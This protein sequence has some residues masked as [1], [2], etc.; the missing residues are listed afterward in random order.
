[1]NH[2][3]SFPNVA[4]AVH[5]LVTA[6]VLTLLFSAG[7]QAQSSLVWTGVTDAN[8]DTTT[9]NWVTVPGG[10]A[11]AFANGDTVLFD[12]TSTTG[13]VSIPSAVSPGGITVNKAGELAF[14][15]GP[16]ITG[17]TTLLKQNSGTLGITGIP[18]FTG[19]ASVEGGVVAINGNLSASSWVFNTPMQL[20]GGTVAFSNSLNATSVLRIDKPVTIPDGAHGVMN[21]TRTFQTRTTFLGA[22]TLTLNLVTH[23]VPRA[24]F[25]SGNF[26]GFSGELRLIGSATARANT[27]FASASWINTSMVLDT[28]GLI[29]DATANTTRTLDI[30]AL[31]SVDNAGISSVQV[32]GATGNTVFSIG[33]R[34]L[35]TTFHGTIIGPLAALT[36]VGSGMLTLTGVNTYTG[37]TTVA[38]GGLHVTGQLANTAQV[39]VAGGAALGGSGTITSAGVTYADDATLLVDAS[40]SGTLHGLEVGGPVTLGSTLKVTPVVAD[41][42][43]IISGVY[44]L[45]H[46]TG[47]IT[48]SPAITLEYSGSGVS[49]A[50][51]QTADAIT[52]TIT[53]G[54]PPAPVIT[55]LLTA[56]GTEGATFTYTITADNNPTSFNATALPDGLSVNTSSGVISG[57]LGYGTTGTSNITIS[58]GNLGGTDSET[59]AL[60]IEPPPAPVNVPT[61][62]GP[63]AITST[64]GAPFNYQIGASD[65][66]ILEYGAAPLPAA[67]SIDSASGL[68]SG[69]IL[70]SGTTAVVLSA[71]NAAGTGTA[72]LAISAYELPVITSATMAQAADGALFSYT[73][74]AS[75]EPTS[76]TASGLP[77]WLSYNNATHVLS[78]TPTTAGTAN[79]TMTA[80]NPVGSDTKT[81]EITVTTLSPVITSSLRVT[82]TVGVP[83]SYQIVSD[84]SPVSY[85]AVPLPDGLSCDAAT[86]II[87]GVPAAAGASDVLISATNVYGSDEAVLEIIA[88][89]PVPADMLVWTGAVSGT[90]NTTDQNWLRA[91]APATYQDGAKVLFND[92]NETLAIGGTG[93]IGLPETVNPESVTF[94]ISTGTLNMLPV[95]HFG[96]WGGATMLK[97][98]QGTV[99]FSSFN[100]GWNGTTTI[101]EGHLVLDYPKSDQALGQHTMAIGPVVFAGGTLTFTYPD[102]Q[103]QIFPDFTV[104]DGNNAVFNLPRRFDFKGAI[105]GSG[106]L[107]LR[108]RGLSNASARSNFVN[109]FSG[110]SGD[111]IFTGS[112]GARPTVGSAPNMFNWNGWADVHLAIQDQVEIQPQVA[113]AGN[114]LVIGALSGTSAQAALGSG[115]SNRLIT[116]R[117]GRK[118]LSTTFAGAILG[119]NGFVNGAGKT[120]LIKEG[121]GL[122]TLSGSLSYTGTT[123]VESGGLR[124]TGKHTGTEPIIVSGSAG[125]GGS[126]EITPAITYADG[127]TL[128]LDTDEAGELS[129]P[130]V[131]GGTVTFGSTLKVSPVVAEGG[132]VTNGV[133]TIF[134]SEAAFAGT[135]SLVWSHPE[136]PAVAAAFDIVNGSQIQ[137]TI[138]GGAIARPR[139]TSALIADALAG[140]PFSYTLTATIDPTTP[141]ILSVDGLPA[142][143]SFNPA[144]GIISGSV[145]VADTYPVALSASNSSGT[146]T[147]TLALIVYATP[148]PAPLITSGTRV[149]MVVEQSGAYTITAN[150]NPTG[151]DATDLPDGLS[152][153]TKTGVIS[154]KPT[155]VGTGTVTLSASNI[156]GTGTMPLELVVSLPPPRFSEIRV[157]SNRSPWVAVQ[158]EPVKWQIVAT[159][160]PLSYT[161]SV[162][163]AGFDTSFSMDTV[164]GILDAQFDMIG[165][166]TLLVTYANAAGAVTLVAPFAVNPPSPVVIDA[167]EQ[168]TGAVGEPFSYT[169][170]ATNMVPGGNSTAVGNTPSYGATGLPPGLFI[171]TVTGV[172]SG[173]P[174]Y[175]GVQQGAL[176]AINVT[177]VGNKPVSFAISGASAVVSLA[178]ESGTP[179]NVDGPGADA[180]FTSPGAGI[181]DKDG[182]LYIADT[183]NNSIRK[184]ALDGTV[185]TFATG[186]NAPAS[187]VVDAAG[188]TLY[189]ANTG[190][191]TIE[192]I[193]IATATVTALA[194]TGAPALNAPHGL[195]IDSDG[196]LYVADTG[197][198]SIR[199]INTTTGD[200]TVIAGSGATGSDDGAGVAA[201]FDMPMGLALDADATHLYIADTGNSIIRSITLATG[202]VE[203]VAGLAHAPGTDNGANADARFN[204]PQALAVDAASGAIYVADTGNNAIRVIDTINGTVTTMP[205]GGTALNAPAGI[206]IDSTGDIYVPDTGN[207]T[208]CALQAAPSIL[209]SPVAQSVPVNTSATFNVAAIGA[210]MPAYQWYR[211]GRLITGG[212]TA[213]LVIDSVQ[214]TDVANYNVTV[215]NPMGAVQTGDALLSV[216]GASPTT[217]S[218]NGGG[219][220]GGAPGIWY[221]PALALLVLLRRMSRAV[222]PKPPRA[223]RRSA[224]AMLIFALC[225]SALQPFNPLVF[226][227]Q[228]ATGAISGRV[229]NQGTG[230]YLANAL[231]TIEGTRLETLTDGDGNYRFFDAPAG[232]VR[233]TASYTD[234]DRNSQVVAVVAGQTATADFNLTTQVYQ[235]ERFVVAGDREGAALATQEQRMSASQKAVFAADSFGNI[236]DSN[237]GELMKNLPGITIDYDGEDAGSMRIRGMDPEFANVTLDGNAVASMSISSDES[238]VGTASR[239]FNLSTQSLQNI[240]SIELK[241]A[242]TA[243]D[244]A[245]SMGGAV[246]I[247]TK[248]ALSQKGR[249]MRFA[250]NLSLNTA[251]LDFD[252]TPGGGRTPDYKIWPG[253][254]F[255]WGEAFGTRQRFGFSFN[256]AFNRNYRFN[257]RYEIPRYTYDLADLEKTGYKVTPT[258]PGYVT[259]LRYTE[260]GK[261]EQTRMVSLNLEYQPWQNTVFFLNSSYNDVKGLGAYTRRM[262]VTAG[263]QTAEANLYN[264]ISPEGARIGMNYGISTADNNTVSFNA[265]ARHTFGKIKVNWGAHY[266]KAETDPD[267]GKNF[268]IEYSMSGVGLNALNIAGNATGEIVQTT[269]GGTGIMAPDDTG[270]YLNLENY[271]SLTLSQ[272]F[273]YGTDEQRGANLDVTIPV[274]LGVPVEFKFGGR[275]GEMTREMH[276]YW[277]RRSLTGNSTLKNF[278]TA[279]EPAIYQFA[280]PYFQNSWGFDV[281]IPNWVNPYYVYDYFNAHPGEF[282]DDSDDVK[283]HFYQQLQGEKTAT[284]KTAAG[285]AQ[286]TA[287]LLRNLTMIAGVRYERTQAIGTGPIY[288]EPGSNDAVF[289]QNGKYDT[290]S[291]Y[292]PGTLD[293]NPYYNINREQKNL[294]LYSWQTFE[295]TYDNVF[296]NIQFKWEPLKNMNVRLARTES[297]GRPKFGNVIPKERWISSELR[298]ERNNPDLK[299]QYA[300]KYDFAVEY[301][302]S[303]NGSLTF[304]LFYQQFKDIIQTETS[305]INVT[306]DEA[307]ADGVNYI[308]DPEYEEGTWIVQSPLNLGEGTNRGFEIVY[309]QR[310]GFLADWLKNFSVYGSFSYADPKTHYM[311]HTIPRP[312]KNVTQ[313]MLD[314]YINSPMVREEIPMTG[315]QK[316]SATLQLRYNGKRFSGKIAA[317]WVDRFAR[318]INLTYV[319]VKYQ[320]AYTRFDLSLAYKINSRW[321]AMFDWRNVTEVGDERSIFDRTGGYFT[322]GMVM[323]V[324]LEANF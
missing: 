65:L 214:L 295:K 45:L 87:S 210:P 151:F 47:G 149:V 177:G 242:P 66:P 219:S 24:D 175:S 323:N 233:V 220:G 243:E 9:Q 223:A 50:F 308:Y 170:Q 225:L 150:H 193:D 215:S 92:A 97:K 310:L 106:T 221:L 217:P 41:G 279:A 98:G 206:V 286:L 194:T 200:M 280:D 181:T 163:P 59:L 212:T 292:I 53:A 33:A 15:A 129:G 267:P 294:L 179:G 55:S 94:A 70:G 113:A 49:A 110:F 11:A 241:T 296:P 102:S 189:V 146:T 99:R 257:N 166:G 197:N 27:G 43:G 271:N 25:N 263:Q 230:K 208:I 313:A 62:S 306:W 31:S 34:N 168:L 290:I 96:L 137:V 1:M 72:T 250:A 32:A 247:K 213:A 29:S 258:T 276:Q 135:P 211:D 30:G 261:S 71:R 74:T 180:R 167:P 125:F 288:E 90:W 133:Y 272:R 115:Q 269:H 192:K 157:L 154:G 229:M 188:T 234:L 89:D 226:S 161:G 321:K 73:I 199:K 244:S 237:M 136:N 12:D 120:T 218:G 162:A 245:S 38:A 278:G 126:G 123:F 112:G 187:I 54:L 281:P 6:T 268:S 232:T 158:G 61:I 238:G 196:N 252:K 118:N 124:M 309:N 86:G 153:N 160:D 7:V 4:A 68:V 287:R 251:E 35:D 239:A 231:V 142:G 21:M 203:T 147:A 176:I 298:I 127:A 2:P 173:T 128:L 207:H 195:A 318:D 324:G 88:V 191:N 293:P 185:S 322:S 282:Y 78:G 302:F 95:A 36:K 101:E 264:M 240:E 17:A 222:L 319:E 148:P 209:V 116:Y 171:D 64:V 140:Q 198:N 77:A 254:T 37:T 82:G 84:N 85:G 186:F 283:G 274:V 202:G 303:K 138:T 305:F 304:S 273:G 297:I 204:M 100:E 253:F 300:T 119:T 103:V 316:K 246:N 8:W 52:A 57:T 182:N 152:I 139:I 289:G 307:L 201:T 249:R 172:I 165:T 51:N 107:E 14:A 156:G 13:T 164:T 3:L 159:N 81:L 178:G 131:K 20:S 174:A 63:L 10:A 46:A 93:T 80:V 205:G 275:Y 23:T 216:T 270:S 262:Q 277:R 317:Y 145:S 183:G 40:V 121:T 114:T 248:S 42:D 26:T 132:A 285:Y 311:R 69:T 224:L 105:K 266:S 79:V 19:T 184:I 76:I 28:A 130:R 265:G 314:E 18:A 104:A 134:S 260:S 91:G 109:D 291:P 108:Y 312:E 117:I 228:S 255:S 301:Y 39:T 144:T 256:T 227:Q 190:A 75:G 320:S 259:E 83:F 155:T 44:T 141:T 60:V 16:M 22:G 5:A 315:I 235:L 48:G 58:A 169:I 56:S 299:P 111:M 122:L 284:E 236:V 143:L 67:L